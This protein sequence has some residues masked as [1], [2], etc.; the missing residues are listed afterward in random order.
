MDKIYEFVIVLLLKCWKMFLYTTCVTILSRPQQVYSHIKKSWETLKMLENVFVH[1]LCN[2][3]E[4]TSTSLQPQ[5]NHR[6]LSQSLSSNFQLSSIEST[7]TLME[8]IICEF[9]CK[10][11]GVQTLIVHFFLFKLGNMSHDNKHHVETPLF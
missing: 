4:Q 3:L 9:L 8:E 5:K 6:K 2:Y 1:F 7:K 11:P 10:C